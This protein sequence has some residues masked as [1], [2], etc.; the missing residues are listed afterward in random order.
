MPEHNKMPVSKI[1]AALPRAKLLCCVHRCL[2]LGGGGEP[3]LT[4]RVD[5]AVL[6]TVAP[7]TAILLIREPREDYY[8]EDEV[9]V[10]PDQLGKIE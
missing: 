8:A 1:R 3:L 4:H 2:P 7:A 10:D 9:V 6:R 5:G